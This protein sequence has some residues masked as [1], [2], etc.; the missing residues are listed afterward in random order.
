MPDIDHLT[1]QHINKKMI[2]QIIFD[3]DGVLVDTEIV[4][5][6]VM[7]DMLSGMG[8]KMDIEQYI[9]EFTGKTFSDIIKHF[10]ITPETGKSIESMARDS[11]QAIY[12]SLRSVNGMPELVKSLKLPVAVA[13]NSNIWQVEK[14]IRFL[15]IENIVNGHYFSSEMVAHPKPFPDVYLLAAERTRQLPENCLVVEDSYSGV[16]AAKDAGMNVIGFCGGSHIR[17]GHAM[18]LQSLGVSAIAFNAEELD[19]VISSLL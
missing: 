15:E 7:I 9:D 13:S 4:A 12:N 18:R 16:K 6:E 11:E 10:D 17:N 3:C 8:I 19:N 14:A 2:S 1:L 5:A